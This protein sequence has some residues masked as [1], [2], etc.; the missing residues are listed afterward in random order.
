MRKRPHIK[1]VMIEIFA[2]Q[3][4]S[5]HLA[6]VKT[7]IVADHANRR[8]LRGTVTYTHVI[9]S[10]SFTFINFCHITK[11]KVVLFTFK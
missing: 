6:E 8:P 1:I 4:V 11:Y 7:S 3:E 5:K 9:Y 10:I 2:F